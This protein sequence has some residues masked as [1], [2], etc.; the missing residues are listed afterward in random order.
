MAKRI[1]YLQR[2]KKE[3][4]KIKR[5]IHNIEKRGYEVGIS[6]DF[7]IPKKV[8]KRELERLQKQYTL[9]NIYQEATYTAPTGEQISGKERRKQERSEA[10]KRGALTRKYKQST[11][12]DYDYS[13]WWSDE[14]VEE[15]DTILD[16]LNELLDRINNWSTEQ[17]QGIDSAS[18]W[19]AQNIIARKERDKEQLK[20][21]I[22]T[23]IEQNGKRFTARSIEYNADEIFQIADDIMY[24]T[25]DEINRK[26]YDATFDLNRIAYMLNG[27]MVV[28]FFK[29]V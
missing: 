27:D 24:K 6:R 17:I 5:R 2:Y 1:T 21:A 19:Y 13:D 10:S 28:N 9:E 3:I 29:T 26:E 25:Y 15:A 22:E 8:G 20:W 4:T 14:P 16:N 18:K 11:Y 12:P 7:T 23:L